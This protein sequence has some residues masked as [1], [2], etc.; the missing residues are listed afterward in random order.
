MCGIVGAI[1]V[2]HASEKLL[3]GI[4]SLEYRGYDSCGIAMID[5]GKISIRKDAGTVS[6]VDEKL[7]FAELPGAAGIAHTRW[8]THGRVNQVNAHPH[9]SMSGD[10]AI[11]HNGII[12]NY[13]E[14]K[15]SLRGEG[16]EFHTETDSEV[17]ANLLEHSYRDTGDVEAA[18]VRT[19]RRL[20]GS[21]AILAV[22]THDPEHIYAARLESPL[23][24][25]IG[26]EGNYIG[27]DAN[28]FIAYTRNAVP[29][30]DGEYAVVGKDSYQIRD[31]I[32]G[33]LVER[34]P[35]SVP[36]DVNES[37][38]GGYPHFMLKEIHEQPQAI[39][40]ALSADEEA[41]SELADRI[42][43][44]GRIYLLGVGTTFYVSLFGQYILKRLAGVF[45]PAMSSDE[46]EHTAVVEP[47][48]LVLACSQSGET[49]DTIMALR[50]AKEGGAETAA[51]VN[52]VGSSMTRVVDHSV[53]QS[54][55]PEIC[56]ISTKAAMAQMLILLRLA[57]EVAR[58]RGILSAGED[59]TLTDA[60]A[61]LPEMIRRIINERSGTIRNLA[62]RHAG[63]GNWIFLGRGRY[64]PIAMESALKMK[65]VSY[66]HSEGM[67][68]GF[69][70]HGTLALIDE[71]VNTLV[72][73]PSREESDLFDTTHSS[74]EE[75]KA[76]EGHLVG[77]C[78]DEDELFHERIVLPSLH[79]LLNPL[80]QLVVGQLFG[81]FT[82]LELGRN[83][84]KPR[85]LAKSVTVP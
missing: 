4:R 62:N 42:A 66:V 59:K 84:D 77:F 3:S 21:Y 65:E 35:F 50:A 27:S 47:G 11:I 16:F 72:F 29:M 54:S 63:I 18:M 80:L 61:K 33:D 70:K 38:K 24:L 67:P 37:Q 30:D 68:A 78:F 81:Y 36:W 31:L 34:K 85:S 53:I 43:G 82:A 41:I 52:V 13:K 46:F 20:E 71:K 12:S 45:A 9:L 57:S 60:L 25:G 69:L 79:P 26:A 49:Y 19:A 23:M 32:T 2:E 51:I 74:A 73:C 76:R 7:N 15:E 28:A 22:T 5:A 75:V 56:V 64:Y 44:A 58:R 1:G 48:T 39:T 8:A 40:Q 14:I 10:F 6:E 17:V 83:I 55:G